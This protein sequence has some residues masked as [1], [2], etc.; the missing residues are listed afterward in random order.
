[1]AE[2]DENLRAWWAVKG[3]SEEMGADLSKHL[4]SGGMSLAE[5]SEV[6]LKCEDCHQAGA[7]KKALR[8]GNGVS[9]AIKSQCP[10]RETFETYAEMQDMVAQ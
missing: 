4:R 6:V 5:I 9:E 8:S 1:M 2:V 7:C 10:N 3:M